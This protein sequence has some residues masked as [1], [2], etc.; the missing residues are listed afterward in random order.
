MTLRLSRMP[1]P[2]PTDISL[3]YSPLAGNAGTPQFPASLRT[4]FEERKNV[5]LYI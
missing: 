2:G 5:E 4:N 1:F 3:P